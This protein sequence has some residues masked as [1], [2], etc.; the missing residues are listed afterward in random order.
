M[1]DEN[2]EDDDHLADERKEQPKDD[3]NHTSTTTCQ[4]KDLDRLAFF[5]AAK[6]YWPKRKIEY[7]NV[8]RSVHNISNRGHVPLDGKEREKNHSELKIEICMVVCPHH[9]QDQNLA[10][11]IDSAHNS[12][13]TEDEVSETDAFAVQDH[14]ASLQLVRMVN[15]VPILDSAE[16]HSCGLVHGLANKIVWGSFGLDIERNT[17]VAS[18]ATALDS[19]DVSSCTPRFHLRDSNLITPFI[20]RNLNHK[21]LKADD[22]QTIGGDCL[23]VEEK[24]KRKMDMLSQ[25]DILPANVRIGSMLVVVHIRAAPSSL[26]LPT[27]S[28]VSAY[29]CLLASFFAFARLVA[30][31]KH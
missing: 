7:Q 4:K 9:R 23:P 10:S 14:T 22:Q 8:A 5:R 27:L 31:R 19:S 20:R 18:D 16:A 3:P 2:G 26:P 30:Q 15:G 6:I 1:D 28:K 24:K 13:S 11:S 17:T 21:Q 12:A 25:N 29:I